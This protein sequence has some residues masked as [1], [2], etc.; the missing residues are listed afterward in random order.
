MP[1]TNA[2]TVPENTV[3][4][5]TRRTAIAAG[6][7]VV[8]GSGIITNLAQ[9]E[10]FS[11]QHGFPVIIKACNGGGGRGIRIVH[12][13]ED[14]AQLYERCRSEALAAFGNGDVFVELYVDRGRHIEVQLLA[15]GQ[16][17]VIHLY[18][19]DCSV[20]R[21]HQKV[22]EIAPA[23]HLEESVR[24]AI[25][26]DAI[27]MARFV[28]YRNAGTAEFLVDGR[29]RHFFMEINPRIQVCV[30]FCSAARIISITILIIFF[31][32]K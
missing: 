23:M 15:D 25:L 21:R 12:H 27:T 1:G 9:V 26:A 10:T 31:I 22:V 17:N 32:T 18:E 4:A 5:H 24:Q 28:G 11:R 7:P 29:G 16:G 20:Q 19:R 14:L 30:F 3:N 8:P 6:L 2:L 13:P